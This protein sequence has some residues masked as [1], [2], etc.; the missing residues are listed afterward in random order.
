MKLP[1]G[2]W[3][4]PSHLFGGRGTLTELWNQRVRTLQHLGIRA[5]L[6]V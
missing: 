3:R 6:T 4:Q 2:F 5:V 1:L